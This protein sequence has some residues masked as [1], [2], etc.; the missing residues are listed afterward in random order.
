MSASAGLCKMKR[1][2]EW[3]K[4]PTVSILVIS[5]RSLQHQHHQGAVKADV[6]LQ[7]RL[8]S[9]PSPHCPG[10]SGSLDGAVSTSSR[11]PI[12]S[13]TTLKQA[14]TAARATAGETSFPQAECSVVRI[15]MLSASIV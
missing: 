13:L 9:P 2:R 8:L 11:E 4:D 1:G 5:N 10:M 3:K 15:S 14:T 7:Q 6:C 12:S